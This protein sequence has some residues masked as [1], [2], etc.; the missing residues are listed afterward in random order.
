MNR[1]VVELVE[2]PLPRDTPQGR[3]SDR[4]GAG[5]DRTQ[6]GDG[7]GGEV[8][9]AVDRG[10]HHSRRDVQAEAMQIVAGDEE[11]SRVKPGAHLEAETADPTAD[12]ERAATGIGCRLEQRED[13]ITRHLDA[14]AVVMVDLHLND[15]VVLAEEPIPRIVSESSR[16]LGRSDDVGYED[17]AV[18]APRL[19]LRA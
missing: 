6:R 4:V 13:A 7:F 3:R 11:R 15:G 1:E 8:H 10:F 14:C 12:H 9:P 17:R 19:H 2:V 5:Y 18:D 16:M